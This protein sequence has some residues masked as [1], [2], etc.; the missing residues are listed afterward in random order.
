MQITNKQAIDYFKVFKILDL[1]KIEKQGDV[2]LVQDKILGRKVL[3]VEGNVSTQNSISFPTSDILKTSP[4]LSF[5]QRFL[6]MIGWSDPGKHFCFQL[7][8][9]VSAKT[10][11]VLFSTVYKA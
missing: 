6:Y 8:L 3:A 2:K 4:N 1:K 5:S 11:K 7:S 9:S 10:H